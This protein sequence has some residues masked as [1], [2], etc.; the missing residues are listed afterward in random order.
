MALGL[1]AWQAALGLSW[2]DALSATWTKG[3][4]DG[5][6]P[7]IFLK[8]TVPMTG[9]SVVRPAHFPSRFLWRAYEACR[10]VAHRAADGGGSMHVP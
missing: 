5:W 6:R 8:G 1:L 4:A 7:A 2:Q 9:R 3:A 10:Y